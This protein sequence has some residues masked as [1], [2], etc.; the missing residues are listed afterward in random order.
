MAT[1]SA[2]SNRP[3]CSAALF[4]ELREGSAIDEGHDDEGGAVVLADVEDGADVGV[5]DASG[6]PGLALEAMDALG[7][8]LGRA[9][10]EGDLEGDDAV[11]VGVVGAVDGAHA[12]GAKPAEDLVPADGARR[13]L[14]DGRRHG[15]TQYVRY[16]VGSQLDKGLH[17]PGGFGRTGPAKSP[18]PQISSSRR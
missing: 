17:T 8:L 15:S 7:A 3:R 6:G 11:E 13:R 18:A 2:G 4:E 9:V 14:I 12:A 1:A 5:E 10:E 16:R